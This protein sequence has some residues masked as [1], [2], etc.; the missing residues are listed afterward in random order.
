LN[1]YPCCINEI[2]EKEKKPKKGVAAEHPPFVKRV[3]RARAKDA[4]GKPLNYG[5]APIAA[6]AKDADGA[7]MFFSLL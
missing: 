2:I 6:K 7:R 1:L 3:W 5:G 4:E